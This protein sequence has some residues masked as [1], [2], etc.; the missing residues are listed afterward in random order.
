METINSRLLLALKNKKAVVWDFDGV[1][2]FGNWYYDEDLDIWKEKLWKLLE[3]Y[4]PKIR[5]RYKLGMKYPYEHTDDIAG[6]F[7]SAAMDEINRFYLEK[8]LRIL[9][10]SPLNA[11]LIQLIKNLDRNVEHHIWSNNQQGFVVEALENSGI[12]DRFKTIVTRDRVV[13]AKPNLDGFKIISA[14]TTARVENFIFVG[15]SRNTDEIV[16]RTLNM[17]FF[18]YSS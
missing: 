5:E 12:K 3:K 1:L 13:K 11:G 9:P 18:F 8:E 7:G 16:A 2:C 14:A 6:R 17:D 4:D 15:D 10:G